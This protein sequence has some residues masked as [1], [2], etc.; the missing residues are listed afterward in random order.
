LTPA[1]L[2]ENQNCRHSRE[3]VCGHPFPTA[4]LREF[5]Y[6][7]Q[8]RFPASER[9][10]RHNRRQI[11]HH[12]QSYRRNPPEYRKTFRGRCFFLQ[13]TQPRH[14]SCQAHNP[15]F[16]YIYCYRPLCNSPLKEKFE[17]EKY[18]AFILHTP[19]QN[20]KSAV[21]ICQLNISTVKFKSIIFCHIQ[22]VPAQAVQVLV[23]LR[24]ISSES[25]VFT[26]IGFVC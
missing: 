8:S 18:G 11:L 4:F 24:K 19:Y 25:S 17:T 16:Y 9:R 13:E 21:T 10:L 1:P 3:S 26:V 12:C 7:P 20:N 5:P 22:K 23:D 6:R 14:Q 15:C 2:S